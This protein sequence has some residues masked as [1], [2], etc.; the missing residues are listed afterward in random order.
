MWIEADGKREPCPKCGLRLCG[1]E[2]LAEKLPDYEADAAREVIAWMNQPP[3]QVTQMVNTIISTVA[4]KASIV[5]P[6]AV[7][8][9]ITKYV[10]SILELLQ[11]L[12]CYTVVVD[13]EDLRKRIEE[14][15]GDNHVAR[16]L[17]QVLILISGKGVLQEANT[18]GYHTNTIRDLQSLSLRETDTLV[19]RYMGF[20][21]N[22]AFATAEGLLSGMGGFPLLLIDIPMITAINFRYL[23]QIASCF[24]YDQDEPHEKIATM[25]V[26]MTA[27][28]GDSG[29]REG[30]SMKILAAYELRALAYALSRNWTYAQMAE[31]AGLRALL[32]WLKKNAPQQ[33]ARYVTKRKAAAAIPVLGAGLGATINYAM[34]SY[35]GKVG[36]YYY[37]YRKI[38]E[39]F[40]GFQMNAM[41][42]LPAQL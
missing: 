9:Q 35:T 16:V 42:D 1:F 13:E 18:L 17:A 20:V 11:D 22:K 14:R 24:G 39:A 37:R 10:T 34:T 36:W 8:D 30:A 3:G 27:F 23:Q 26:F 5:V 40:G 38:M 12:S 28:G 25:R 6:Q 41:P 31:K 19:G 2:D 15:L 29:L 21:G 4:E 7:A 32:A 33:L